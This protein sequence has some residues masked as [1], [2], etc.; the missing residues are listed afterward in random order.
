MKE[1]YEVRVIGMRTKG[2]CCVRCIALGEVRGKV[3]KL[4]VY[5]R[6]SEFKLYGVGMKGSHT[7]SFANET[8]TSG[9]FFGRLW[10]RRNPRNKAEAVF[11]LCGVLEDRRGKYG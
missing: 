11:V 9:Q 7:L 6:L 10:C 2:Q 4:A 3:P 8:D 5:T 1:A